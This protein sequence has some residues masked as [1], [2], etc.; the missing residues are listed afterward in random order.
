MWYVHVPPYVENDLRSRW[1]DANGRTGTGIGID[2]LLLT[3]V[4]AA[5]EAGAIDGGGARQ[6]RNNENDRR[7]ALTAAHLTVGFERSDLI[8]PTLPGS[9]DSG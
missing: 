8:C 4:E 6:H 7:H 2:Q 1:R 3:M 5:F 9:I